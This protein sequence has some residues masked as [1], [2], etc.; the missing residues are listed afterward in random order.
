MWES[1]EAVVPRGELR[2]S[3][4][5]VADMVPPPGSDADAEMRAHLTE[6]I[7]TVTPFLKILTEVIEFG[8]APEGEQ[9]LAAMKAL[10]RL[11]DRRTR[12]TAADIDLGLLSG[13]W[14]ALVMPKGGGVDRSAWVFCVLTAFHRH[15]RRREIYAE[16]ST[17]WRDPRAQLLAGEK[18]ARAKVTVLA[19]LQL[20]EDPDALLAE[21]SR[22]LDAALRDVAAQVSAGTID[23]TVDDQGRL[24]LPKLS[25]IPD[26]PSP[27][28][29]AQAGRRRCCRASTCPRSSWR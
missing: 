25:A 7:A 12:I 17:R 11:L 19:A 2:E 4:D 24:H 26:P 8:A 16:A 15:L 3:V 13:S 28:R 14:R 10:P 1:I 5:A 29:P 18:L 6:R 23:A 27:D 9:A 20:G 22:A 21:Q